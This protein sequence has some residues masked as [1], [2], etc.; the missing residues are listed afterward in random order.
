MK[1]ST[2]LLQKVTLEYCEKKGKEKGW[3]FGKSTV[4]SFKVSFMYFKS[5]YNSI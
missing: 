2:H 4:A 5:I 1:N 3:T